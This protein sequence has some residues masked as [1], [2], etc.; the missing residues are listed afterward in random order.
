MT[1][2]TV[3]R[4]APL[5]AGAAVLVLIAGSAY[6]LRDT[7][8][9]PGSSTPPLLR[10][11]AGA[12]SAER[13]VDSGRFVVS[14]KLPAGPASARV[15]R[16]GSS[17][18]EVSRLADALGVDEAAVLGGEGLPAGSGTVLRVGEAPGGQWQFVRADAYVCQ[19]PLAGENPDGSASSTC[20]APPRSGRPAV[21][22]PPTEA[23]ARKAA[24]PVLAAVGL[25]VDDAR[26]EPAIDPASQQTNAAGVAADTRTVRVNPV[27]DG[28][29][30]SGL[31]TTV[32]VDAD[33]VLAA[34]GWL[35]DARPSDTYPV[36]T[37]KEALARLAAMPVPLIACAESAKPAPP[38][39]GCGG[40]V[41]ITGASFGL[42]VQWE[43]DRAVLVPSWLF[44]TV[45][46]VEPVAVVAVDSAYLADALPPDQ[47]GDGASG[48]GSGMP[49]STG[50]AEPGTVDPV[51][52]AVEPSAATSRFDSVEPVAGGAALQVTF[53]GG[54]ESCYTYTVV[55]EED[56]T[57]VALRLVETR[58]GEICIDLAQ[59]YERAVDLQAPLGSR[60]V[61]DADTNVSLYPVRS[62][63]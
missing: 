19:D 7:A 48:S 34:S 13:Q 2:Q 25:D 1:S 56:A 8:N 21:A 59:Q 29:P 61:V 35:G 62:G 38:G 36:V 15:H 31:A 37:A 57:Q 63:G 5:A 16:F 23:A 40:P 47:P 45:G 32:T 27:V 39:P 53:Y 18:L 20:A 54:V 28:H 42:S 6:F 24:R 51:A 58:N 14:G 33:G 50:G 60:R 49:G 22:D 41:E 52:P 55:A 4:G 11:G 10:I 9:E 17:D 43:R 26:S 44:D 46:G 3:R 12:E 30:T